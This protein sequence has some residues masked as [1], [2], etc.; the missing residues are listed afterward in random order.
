M[1]S[2]FIGGRTI[3]HYSIHGMHVKQGRAEQSVCICND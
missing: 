1:E 3:I 2:L